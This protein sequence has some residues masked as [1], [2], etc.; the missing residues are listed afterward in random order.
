MRNILT[1]TALCS[2]KVLIIETE[3]FFGASWEDQFIRYSSEL[4]TKC[5]TPVE[6]TGVV[7]RRRDFSVLTVELTLQRGKPIGGE[8]PHDLASWVNQFTG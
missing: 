6:S 4:H 5:P 2:F 7:T 1:S 3:K 8:N